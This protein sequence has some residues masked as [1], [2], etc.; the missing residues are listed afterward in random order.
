MGRPHR[1]FHQ[2]AE[3]SQSL[4]E[5]R[6]SV[7]RRLNQAA[8]ILQQEAAEYV[9]AAKYDAETVQDMKEFEARASKMYELAKFLQSLRL[10]NLPKS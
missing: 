3:V 6:A 8:L 9:E 7:A 4:S 10:A 1:G 5:R 2:G